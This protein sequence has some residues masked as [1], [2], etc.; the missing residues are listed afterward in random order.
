MKR[1]LAILS[2][3]LLLLIAVAL[4]LLAAP[5]SL[6]PTQGTDAIR[7]AVQNRLE[8]LPDPDLRWQVAETVQAGDWAYATARATSRTSGQPAPT[9]PLV[10]LARR[11]ADGSWQAALPGERLFDAWL[12]AAPESLIDA[13]T[14]RYLGTSP[15]PAGPQAEVTG[16]KV[17]WL[18]GYKGTVVRR[19][20]TNHDKQVDFNLWTAS[21]AWGAGTVAAAKGGTVV[22]A[23]D[24]S[25]SGCA[26]LDCWRQAN[27]VVIR[28]AANEYS[29]YVHLA[30]Q[31]VPEGVYAGAAIASGEPIGVEGETGFATGVHLHYM[32]S[33]DLPTLPD[34]NDPNA[35][36]WPQNRLT[37][38]FAEAAW[39]ELQAGLVLVSQNSPGPAEC[40]QAGGAILYK[41][42][43]YDCGGQGEGLGYVQRSDPGWQNVPA[44]FNDRAS[45]LHLPAGA[46]VRLHEH[47][48]RAG[49]SACRSS[50]EETFEGDYFDGGQVLLNDQVSSFELFAGSGCAPIPEAGPQKWKARYDAGDACW[51]DSGCRPSLCSETLDGPGLAVDWAAGAP[52]GDLAGDDWV[53]EFRTALDFDQGEYVFYLDHNGGAQLWLDGRKIAHHDGPGARQICDGDGGYNLDGRHSLRL[54]LREETGDAQV[55]LAWDTDAS[56]CQPKPVRLDLAT[57]L[58]YRASVEIVLARAGKLT[59]ACRKVVET[60]AQGGIAGLDLTGCAQAGEVYDVYVK[61]STALRQV[62]P[63]VE[64]Q[65]GTNQLALGEFV[66]GDT[67]WAG[68]PGGDNQVNL[69]DYRNVLDG[70][71]WHGPGPGRQR[72]RPGRRPGP[73]HG[74]R[75]VG[76]AWRGVDGCITLPGGRCRPR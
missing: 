70:H 21:S 26:S 15:A 10:I 55:R 23:K 68:Q 66:A 48:D 63:A 52:C 75:P 74:R 65:Q 46:S 19:D 71:G 28:H 54:L 44:G 35:A 47:V 27:M 22:F 24:S 29:W 1:T 17:P 5:A 39:E 20:G 4:P 50:D 41:H 34:P 51:W 60:D 18:E 42:A 67:T 2:V 69:M 64:F 76:E 61:P 73:G 25:N 43:G 11:A 33:S 62:L 45:S 36:A 72:R 12:A 30:Y 14:K 8:T 7:A 49:A 37:F 13:Q 3:V 59:C 40:P 6:P 38:D 57:G 9:E 32:V 53:G 58:T 16:Y 31:S 56:A